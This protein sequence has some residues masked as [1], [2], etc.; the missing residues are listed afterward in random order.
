MKRK[1]FPLILVAA[2]GACQT[3][4]SVRKLA[5]SSSALITETRS[6]APAVQQYFARQDR[7]VESRIGH[8]NDRRRMA[9]TASD[10]HEALWGIDSK[11]DKRLPLLA[12]VR[13]T[14]ADVP[15]LEAP[16]AVAVQ[17]IDPGSIAKMTALLETV[18]S[19]KAEAASFYF[20]YWQALS[21]SLDELNKDAAT[22]TTAATASGSANG[23]PQP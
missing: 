22:A 18:A 23:S 16:G 19:G 17:P 6:A 11:D 14:N 1:L 12:R 9:L 4:D 20:G 13:S 3:P 10:P 7:H 15:P 21:K 2:L 5:R 8:W